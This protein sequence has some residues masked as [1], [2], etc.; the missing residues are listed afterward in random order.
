MR[1]RGLSSLSPNSRLRSLSLDSGLQFSSMHIPDGLLTNRMAISLDAVSGAGVLFAAARVKLEEAGPRVPMMGVLAAFVFAAQMLNF[2]I[3]GGTSGHLIGGALLG[4]V[5]GPV[6]GFLTMATVVIAQ[7][8]FL[9]DGG[10]VALGANVFNIAGVTTFGGYAVFRLL[11]GA[12]AAGRAL[13]VAAFLAAWVSLLLSAAACS[14]QMA[15]S[16][17]IALRVGLPAMVGYHALIGLVEGAL[18]A[19]VL[20]FLAR[21][22]PDL[23]EANSQVR[24]R[25]ADWIGALVLVAIP[26]VILALAGASSLPDPLQKLLANPRMEEGLEAQNLMSA[27]RFGEYLLRSAVF[28]GLIGLAYITSRLVRWKR[29]RQ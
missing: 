22:R 14:L 13:P 6:A 28:V 18:T 2:P 26:C 24:L 21:V 5:L 27:G 15:L 12:R 16:G 7:A 20:T 4:I 19:G 17:A 8:L 29:G 1:I 23:M 11:G 9:Q 25:I 10:L 3:L